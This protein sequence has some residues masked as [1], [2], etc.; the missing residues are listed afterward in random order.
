MT[1]EKQNTLIELRRLNTIRKDSELTE[2]EKLEYNA[3]LLT[4]PK[5]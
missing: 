3:L 5:N 1:K 2:T 4:M